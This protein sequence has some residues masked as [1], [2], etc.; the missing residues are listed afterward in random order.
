MCLRLQ[1]EPKVG[2]HL[3]A[4]PRPGFSLPE[5]CLCLEG[6]EH[7]KVGWLEARANPLLQGSSPRVQ[8]C[9]S[10]WRD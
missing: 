5:G 7:S 4:V 8:L 9:A 3:A 10:G 1:V 6:P 2:K